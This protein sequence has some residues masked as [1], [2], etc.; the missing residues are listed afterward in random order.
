MRLERIDE[1]TLDLDLLGPGTTVLDVGCR[2]FHLAKHLASLGSK[3]LC[4]DPSPDI[5]DPQAPNITFQRK[6][7]LGYG[8]ASQRVK[9]AMV[10]D[11]NASFVVDGL[12]EPG[13][14][15]EVEATTI[16][17]L[18]EEHQISQVDAVKLDCEGSEYE[19]LAAWPGP[20]AKQISVEF[21]LHTH[22][23]R[24]DNEIERIVSYLERW[25]AVVSHKKSLQHGLPTL[26]YWDSL[27]LLR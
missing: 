25:Y 6:A 11:K 2:G 17:A 4:L 15:I 18:L 22:S 16:P 27:F 12:Y 13:Q 7:V 3:I 8:P 20:I 14:V 26:N 1:H 24:S 21:H 10:H 19:I 5:V 9:F 23:A